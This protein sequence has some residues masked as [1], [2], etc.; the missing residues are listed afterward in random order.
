MNIT[1][2]LSGKK[3]APPLA[4]FYLLGNLEKQGHSADLRYLNIAV[5]GKG[6][7]QPYDLEKMREVLLSPNDTIAIGCMN[8]LLPYVLFVLRE[9][10][11]AIR[12][13]TIILGG[14]GP[15]EIAGEIVERF[16]FIDFVVKDRHPAILANLLTC[17]ETGGNTLAIEGVVQ[18]DGAQLSYSPSSPDFFPHYVFPSRPFPSL[19]H[20]SLFRLISVEGCPY[21]CTFCDASQFLSRRLRFRDMAHV[22]DEIEWVL[23]HAGK[24]AA[25]SIVDEAFVVKRKWVVQFCETLKERGLAIEWGCYGRIDRVDEELLRLMRDAGC[26]QI[27]FGIDSGADVV[28]EKIKKQLDMQEVMEKLVLAKK[29]IR[30]VTASFIWGYPFETYEDFLRTLTAIRGLER[31]GITTQLH[32]LVP[33]RATEIYREYL[34]TVTFSRT[35]A[36]ST[37]MKPLAIESEAYR[38]FVEANADIFLAYSTFATPDAEKKVRFLAKINTPFRE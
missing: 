18:R 9:N 35:N 31:K 10:R 2:I 12:D 16:D 22:M 29:H 32:Q 7:D 24:Q 20:A 6:D 21:Q 8:D 3:T 37:V 5:F 30:D 17:L 23:A 14:T 25:F 13:K 28:L 19:E 26:T 27:Y 15:A 38:C 36:L 1:L 4:A 34:D 11:E 33:V